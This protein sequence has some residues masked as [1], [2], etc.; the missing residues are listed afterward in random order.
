MTTV[1]EVGEW[2]AARSG[3]TLPWGKTR[4]LIVHKAVWVP[5]PVWTGGKSRPPPE[6][7]AR[8]V[9]PVVSR[10]T[11]W[12]I[13]PTLLIFIPS[14]FCTPNYESLFS[15]TTGPRFFLENLLKWRSTSAPLSCQLPSYYYPLQPL[16]R[17]LCGHSWYINKCF[18]IST[19][20]IL[21]AWYE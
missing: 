17:Q 13:R 19:L 6:F 14:Y 12:A 2:S 8:T 10:Y 3:R 9:Q 7:D 18:N 21:T 15:F 5:G 4:Y 16:W 11:D 1:L 20:T